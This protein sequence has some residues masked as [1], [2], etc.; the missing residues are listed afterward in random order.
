MQL[1]N[2]GYCS[3]ITGKQEPLRDFQGMVVENVIKVWTQTR[4]FIKLHGLSECIY[5]SAIIFAMWQHHAMLRDF[6]VAN[7]D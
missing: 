1:C 5:A 3:K 7:V 6:T 2:F 4:K